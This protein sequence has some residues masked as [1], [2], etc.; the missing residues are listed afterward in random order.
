MNRNAALLFIALSGALA[1][2]G[3]GGSGTGPG[4]PPPTPIASATP[5]PAVTA[6]PTPI[7][8]PTGTTGF[9]ADAILPSDGNA[10]YIS[11][12][13]V[14]TFNQPPNLAS[15]QS[16]ISV[17]A[18]SGSVPS[19]LPYRL[20]TPLPAS[21]NALPL[22][23]YGVGGASYHIAI[24]S[25]ATSQSG[26]PY[27]GIAQFTV[28]LPTTPPLPMPIAPTSGSKYFYGVVPQVHAPFTQSQVVS[29]VQ[30]LHAG[31]VRLGTDMESLESTQ[32][33]FNY[34]PLDQEMGAYAAAKI[35]ALLLIT[36]Y[37]TP[38]WANDAGQA[39]RYIPCQPP[40]LCEFRRCSGASRRHLGSAL[41]A[42]CRDRTR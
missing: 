34:L 13:V 36:Q 4:G 10:A 18:L 22:R 37:N 11:N 9:Y 15:M 8:T 27:G 20:A 28:T 42:A 5:T 17:Q 1:A 24:G 39:G 40:D 38:A 6:P 32:N 19:P 41:S 23:F 30:Q 35:P 31:I 7:P 21:P 2:C 26:T 14:I 33:S 12:P 29:W 25:G 3:G 16:A